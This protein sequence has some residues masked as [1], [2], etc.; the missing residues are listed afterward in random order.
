VGATQSLV[1][2]SPEDCG[3][4]ALLDAVVAAVEPA[5][6]VYILPV[7][8]TPESCARRGEI[9]VPM[10]FLAH[11][12]W[13]AVCVPQISQVRNFLPQAPAGE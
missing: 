5:S 13:A 7:C 10:V 1:G 11:G 6:Y 2:K 9:D 8:A 12:P 3:N 4:A